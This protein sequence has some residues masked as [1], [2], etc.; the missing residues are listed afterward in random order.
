MIQLTFGHVDVGK[1]SFGESVVAFSLAGY[2]SSPSVTSLKIE[3]A[4]DA[5]SD[6]TLL[7]NG[8]VLL[9]AAAGNIRRSKKQRYSTSRN[10]VLLPTFL[11]KAAILHGE[12][13]TCELLKI[14]S[15]SV[16]KWVKEEE[17]TSE[18]DEDNNNNSIITIEAEDTK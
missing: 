8:E 7:P 1:K 16:T 4:F 6:K 15:H 12:L 3:I 9:H 10:V 17:T 18:A 11:M 2:L 14:F 5:D 13:D